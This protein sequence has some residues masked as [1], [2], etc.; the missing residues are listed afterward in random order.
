MNDNELYT[1][2]DLLAG[3][4]PVDPTSFVR[5]WDFRQ[6]TAFTADGGPV[7]K[8]LDVRLRQSEHDARIGDALRRYLQSEK[9]RLVGV[10][11]GHSLDRGSPAYLAIANLARELTRARYV[12][13]TGGGPGAMEAAHVGAAFAES[14]DVDYQLALTEL[15]RSPKLPNLNGLV[16]PDGTIAPG[17]EAV[18]RDAHAWLL[19][20]VRAKALSGQSAGRSLAI[21]TWLYGAEPTIPFATAYAKYYQN[22]IREE[23]LVTEARAGVI[24]ARGGGGTMREIFQDVERN[25]YVRAAA[26]F[27]PMIFVD[28]E[29]YW[30][31][32]AQFDS[33][34]VV[35]VPGIKVDEVLIKSFTFALD[36]AYR[37]DCLA[38]V[39][40][41]TDV[42]TIKRLLAG[43]AP[44][45]A[46]NLDVML[47]IGAGAF[48]S[49]RQ[50][51]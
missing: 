12:V 33:K 34:G 21:P 40:F 3:F 18:V 15:E 30:Q 43:H 39:C 45:A 4:D 32:D 17:K 10:M 36:R 16:N 48:L 20:A 19:A 49:R 14:G 5:T 7:P 51:P 44:E 6:Y 9:P 37:Q 11:G 24:F 38:K 22:S 26:D 23:T 29:G 46:N 50:R 35:T 47:A 2:D 27:I 13:V 28:P 8:S 41:T 42:D 31:R 1:A 25:Y